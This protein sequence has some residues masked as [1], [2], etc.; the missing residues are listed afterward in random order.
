MHYNVGNF[1]SNLRVAFGT[2]IM[3][4]GALY[5]SAWG[6]LGVAVLGSGLLHWCPLYAPLHLSTRER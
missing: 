5:G 1:D 6:L 4:I 3:V 2:A